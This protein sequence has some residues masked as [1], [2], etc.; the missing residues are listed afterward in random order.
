MIIR[1]HDQRL[2][3]ITTVDAWDAAR[4]AGE[5]RAPSLETEGFIHLSTAAQWL[6]TAN[7]FYRGQR[8]LV[9]LV[10]MPDRLRAEVRY[11]SADGDAYPHL[12]GALE[13]DVVERAWPLPVE[14]DGTIAVPAG[15]AR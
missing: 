11:E 9:L 12:Y 7:R 1:S 4:A 13:L 14:P 15:M 10:L 3:H 5:Y 2:F 6:A 8:D